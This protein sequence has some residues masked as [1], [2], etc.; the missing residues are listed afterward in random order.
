MDNLVAQLRSGIDNADG[1]EMGGVVLTM[2]LA[3][4]EIERLLGIVFR[5]DRFVSGL[6]GEDGMSAVEVGRLCGILNG[7]TDI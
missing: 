1:G 6:G 5:A 3:A 7:R 4:D 2:R